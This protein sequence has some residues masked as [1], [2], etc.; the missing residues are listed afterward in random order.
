MK[1]LKDEDDDI[2]LMVSAPAGCKH[3]L[4]YKSCATPTIFVPDPSPS[5]CKTL[6][7]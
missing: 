5:T 7:C 2:V 1:C 3:P 6:Y 4:L